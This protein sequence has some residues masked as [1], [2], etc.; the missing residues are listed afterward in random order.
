MPNMLERYVQFG[1]AARALSDRQMPPPAAAIQTRHVLRL[2]FG[3]TT[4]AVTRPETWKSEAWLSNTFRTDGCVAV[5][6]PA[7]SQFFGRIAPRPR[8]LLL[9]KDAAFLNRLALR[10]FAG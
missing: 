6:G 3:S 7:S 4:R 5:D 1:S 9:K 2:H 8:T 10:V